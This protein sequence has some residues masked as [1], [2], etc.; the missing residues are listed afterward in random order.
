[1]YSP[2]PRSRPGSPPRSGSRARPLPRPQRSLLVAGPAQVPLD[3]ATG[4]LREAAVLQQPDVVDLQVVPL[5][6][7]LADVTDDPG[8]I[9]RPARPVHL[10]CDYHPRPIGAGHLEGGPAPRP[11]PR[12]DGL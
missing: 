6:H 7:R 9:E 10:L 5:R 8:D 4:G 11:Q 3:L 12:V 2:G 1:M